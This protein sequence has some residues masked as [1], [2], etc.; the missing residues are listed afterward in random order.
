MRYDAVTLEMSVAGERIMG[1]Y[2]LL[3]SKS[4]FNSAL[5]HFNLVCGYVEKVAD[6]YNLADLINA[7]MANG[8]IKQ[9]QI[10]PVVNTLLHDKFQYQCIGFNFDASVVSTERVC[11][12][13]GKWNA[14]QLILVYYNPVHGVV[15]SNPADKASFKNVLPLNKNEY[16]L[17]YGDSLV[18]KNKDLLRQAINDAMRVIIGKQVSAQKEYLRGVRKSYDIPKSEPQEEYSE[19]AADLTVSA[20]V[21]STGNYRV[22]PKYSVLVT[23]ELFHNGNV[24][25]WKKIITSYTNKFPNNEVLIWYES[26]RIN[27]INSLFKWGKVKNGTPILVSVAGTQIS[28]VSKLQRYLFE[29]AGPRFESFLRGASNQVL[30]LF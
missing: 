4:G 23:N 30:D 5:R 11:N 21:P 26:E 17:L 29:G 14:L 18:I 10:M 24:E 13:L 20:P 2:D 22:T 7:D 6:G 8:T 12:M 28:S 27:D 16:A 1:R 3:S 19:S 15:I 25:A 9:N